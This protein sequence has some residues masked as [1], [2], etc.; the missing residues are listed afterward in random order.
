[1]IKDESEAGQYA[2]LKRI[3]WKEKPLMVQGV[4]KDKDED[5]TTVDDKGEVVKETY[6]TY[7]YYCEGLEVLRVFQSKT[8]PKHILLTIGGEEKNWSQKGRENILSDVLTL[9]KTISDHRKEVLKQAR[10]ELKQKH[11]INSD[12]LTAAFLEQFMS[13][14]SVEI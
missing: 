3:M 14:D 4:E 1:M 5:K 8:N 11:P 6:K 12:A 2:A 9:Q 13:N 10:D 7:V